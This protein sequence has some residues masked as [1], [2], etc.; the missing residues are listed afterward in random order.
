MS[1]YEQFSFGNFKISVSFWSPVSVKKRYMPV[2]HFA[3]FEKIPMDERRYSSLFAGHL[4]D[5]NQ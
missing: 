4:Q 1:K 3:T 5:T 2:V